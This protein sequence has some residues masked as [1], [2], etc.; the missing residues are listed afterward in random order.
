[1]SSHVDIFNGDADGICS[2]VQIRLAEPLPEGNGPNQHRIV[3][4]VKRD[5][6][7]V[8]KAALKPGDVATVLDIS[9]DK[10]KKPLLEALAAGC[11]VLYID[12]H[13][14]GPIPEDPNLTHRIDESPEWNTA[15]L[16]N[17]H[18][19]GKFPLWAAVGA[20]GD[21]V[22][23]P[24]RRLAKENGL[25]DEQ[26]DLLERLGTYMNYNGYGPSE[27][28]LHFTPAELYR[29]TSR[30]KNPL[31]FVSREPEVFAKL[32]GGYNDDMAKA[33]SLQPVK[34]TASAA[35]IMLPDEKW[36]RRVSGVYSNDLVNL[37]PHRA[38]AVISPNPSGG[39]LVSVRA[40]LDRI[41]TAPPAHELV[42]K[43]PTGG[44][45]AAAAGIN[46]L[47]ESMLDSFVDTFIAYYSE[48]GQK[49]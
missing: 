28:D 14:A 40:P 19:G 44:G 33:S 39:Y 9:M 15:L 35:V 11:R 6:E 10:N 29:L 12:H 1:M 23:E 25:T 34:A 38:H 45:R 37:Y 42:R 20:F 17:A 30:Y 49:M 13:F 36:A 26:T 24:A 47:P 5:I 2:L 21:N 18:L 41:K 7:L 3:T 16:T 22:P 48:D 27:D 4:G 43:F 8:E 31:E 32:E 46:N